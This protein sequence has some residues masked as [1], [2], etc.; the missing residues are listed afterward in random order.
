MHK[1]LAWVFLICMAVTS[2]ANA[3]NIKWSAWKV[4]AGDGSYSTSDCIGSIDT[5]D[6]IADTWAACFAQPRGPLDNRPEYR[7]FYRYKDICRDLF[8]KVGWVPVLSFYTSDLPL[9]PL[10]YY[11]TRTW[12]VESNDIPE[13]Y[14]EVETMESS[15]AFGLPK[16]RPGDTIVEMQSATCRGTNECLAKQKVGDVNVC[17]PVACYGLEGHTSSYI[18]NKNGKDIS[19]APPVQYIILRKRGNTWVSPGAGLPGGR[20][21]SCNIDLFPDHWVKRK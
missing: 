18:C 1:I 17:P 15:P 9:P 4:I 11:R 8:K 2:H 14:N 3:D 12:Q 5:P 6:C 10:Q 7:A 21:Y 19:Y 20:G 16:M 13:R